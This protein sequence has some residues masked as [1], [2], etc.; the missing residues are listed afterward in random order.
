MTRPRSAMR[1]VREIPRLSLVEGLSPRQIGRSLGIA[2]TTV[3][4]TV[5]RADQAGIAWPLPESV[6]DRELEERL[7]A[8]PA[9]PPMESRP[10]PDWARGA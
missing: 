7:F 10:L 9:A 6:D 2:R 8:R 5:E 4:R 3:R 1:K